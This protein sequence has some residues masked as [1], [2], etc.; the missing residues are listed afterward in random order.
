LHNI[1]QAVF[2]IVPAIFNFYLTFFTF[3]SGVKVK[4]FDFY[5][6]GESK[7]MDVDAYMEG[8]KCQCVCDFTCDIIKK[9]LQAV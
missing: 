8:W 9:K 2:S 4:S 7:K 6:G 3:T 1:N 5:P